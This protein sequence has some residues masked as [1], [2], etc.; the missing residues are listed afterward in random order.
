MKL[1]FVA[2]AGLI[3]TV[4]MTNVA[5][6]QWGERRPPPPRTQTYDAWRP[7]LAASAHVM[8]DEAEHLAYYLRATQGAA[9]LADDAAAL[10]R[11]AELF[12]RSVEAGAPSYQLARELQQVGREH[13]RLVRQLQGAH[14]VHHDGHFNA[15][16]Q[17]LTQ[18][19]RA[20]ASLLQRMQAS[21]PA[22]EH[23]PYAYAPYTYDVRPP[24]PSRRYRVRPM[25]QP[26]FE[27]HFRR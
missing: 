4:A 8:S 13:D 3:G 25:V 18:A 19:Y 23:A 26:R 20:T 22:Y 2:L 24:P 15:D 6:A 14:H 9:H 10:A 12:H 17:T 16:F 1:T 11:F 27:I 5:E 21:Y 7:Q